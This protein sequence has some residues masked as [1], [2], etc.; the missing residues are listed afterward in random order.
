MA[1]D[2]ISIIWGAPVVATDVNVATYTVLPT[3]RVLEV[4]YT[5]TN[6]ATINLPSIASFGGGV[7]LTIIDSGYN[8]L[9]KNIIVHRNGTDK[10]N[11]VAGDYLINRNGAAII[12]VANATTS[13]WEII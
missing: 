11:N 5:L 7:N 2:N 3:D 1:Y 12:L 9:V 13:N 4:R 8:A 10:V 6:A